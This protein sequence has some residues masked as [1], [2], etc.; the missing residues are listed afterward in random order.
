MTRK[1]AP[2]TTSSFEPLPA[3]FGM[4]R[5]PSGSI[6]VR[7]DR[8]QQVVTKTFRLS[9]LDKSAQLRQLA[10]AQKFYVETVEKIEKG[11][12][13]DTKEAHEITLGEAIKLYREKGIKSSPK[14]RERD[15]YRIK[16]VMKD[17]ICKKPIAAITTLELTAYRNRLEEENEIFQVE[18]IIKRLKK[19]NSNQSEIDYL[20][21]II[22]L[23]HKK[24]Q[25]KDINIISD[26]NVQI[27]AAKIKY[28]IDNV[29]RMT[30]ANKM[31]IVTRTLKFMRETIPGV[32]VIV[33]P[34]LPKANAGRER[35]LKSGEL[36]ILL[37]K[38]VLQNAL[39]PLIIRFAIETALRLERIL[40]F[41]TEFIV[42]DRRG[43][44]VIDFP[45]ST[46]VR[47]KR[48]GKIPV[49]SE[50]KNI[51][52]EA[53]LIKFCDKSNEIS[54]YFLPFEMNPGTF[55]T[56]WKRLR[57][58]AG[59]ADLH[60]HDLRHE[61]TSRL[62]ERGLD[63][64]EVAT[65]TGHSTNDMLDRYSHYSVDIIHEKLTREVDP[66]DILRDIKALAQKW[67][68]ST[69]ATDITPLMRAVMD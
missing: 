69:G 30:I 58:D 1:S 26:V 33:T 54:G 8:G 37:E 22:K 15:D 67:R 39:M 38:A 61:A 63:A 34:R 19:L 10:E 51:L 29:K 12:P 46:L 25:S 48:T 32:P 47:N 20:G 17:D 2:V 11:L 65:I 64:R 59:I 13:V 42:K 6:R 4:E 52:N 24:Y 55:Q 68:Q 7:T 50:I 60:F 45:K 44:E 14:N 40:T 36:D 28:N 53:K 16:L 57:A 41:S 9:S 5:L 31:Q 18:R 56:R 62:F 66:A 35:R 3:G 27:D 23:I 21:S 43:N 49:T